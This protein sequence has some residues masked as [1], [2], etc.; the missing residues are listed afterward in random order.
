MSRA[1]LL[2]SSV[3]RAALRSRGPTGEIVRRALA[4]PL[5]P[6]ERAFI[7]R[8]E[9]AR[10]ELE[11]RE[12]ELPFEEADGE[13]RRQIGELCRTASKSPWWSELLFRLVRSERPE[14][15]LELG[16][17][18]GVSASYQG[19]A[20]ELNGAGGLTTI[21]GRPAVAAVAARTIADL[22]LKHRVEARVGWFSDVLD[23]VLSDMGRVDY[24]FVDGHHEGPATLEYFRR[25][26]PRLD[27]GAMVIVDDIVWS[28]DMRAAWDT[29][30]SD[31]LTADAV[32]LGQL[33]MWS[34]K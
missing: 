19:A 16:S 3:G 9:Q 29:I 30:C 2:R 32:D 24:A 11:A 13:H 21:E 6:A 22:G 4:S 12:D 25:I 5:E 15:C 14:R 7:D 17:C 10:Q 33:G 34:R 20:L 1:R 31:E 27:K 18:V 8:I 28:S 23:G 26:R